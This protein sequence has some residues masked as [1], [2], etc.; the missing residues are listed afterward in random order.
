MNERALRWFHALVLELVE[1][2]PELVHAALEF[3]A[4]V[5]GLFSGRRGGGG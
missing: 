1:R 5:R 3:S 2:E 4:T